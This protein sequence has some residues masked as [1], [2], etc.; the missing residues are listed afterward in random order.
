MDIVPESE[1]A[2]LQRLNDDTKNYPSEDYNYWLNRLDTQLN[3]LTNKKQRIRKK[4]YKILGTIV[5]NITMSPPS[6][7][8]NACH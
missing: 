5:I 7:V 2:C 1:L 3:E 6:L 4:Y 8:S